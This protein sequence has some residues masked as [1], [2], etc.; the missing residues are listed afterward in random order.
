MLPAPRDVLAAGDDEQKFQ[1]YGAAL[2]LT[3][4]HKN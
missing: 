4:H 3:F 1:N 2:R